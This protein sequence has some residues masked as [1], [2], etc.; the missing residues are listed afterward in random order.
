[1]ISIDLTANL[2]LEFFSNKWHG[3]EYS[4]DAGGQQT[5]LSA[6]HLITGQTGNQGPQFLA[7]YHWFSQ[8]DSLHLLYRIGLTY[9][10]SRVKSP[11]QV[12]R[13]LWLHLNY[14]LKQN[15]W[16]AREVA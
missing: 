4:C 2:N 13:M 5:K 9:V 1:M 12:Q 7:S 8:V 11:S 14:V 3:I 6:S 15:I 16:G 10:L